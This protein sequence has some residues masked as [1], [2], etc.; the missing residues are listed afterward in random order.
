[1]FILHLYRIPFDTKNLVGYLI[2]VTIQFIQTTTNC[3]NN[4][5]LLS[6]GTGAF[7]LLV[8]ATEYIKYDLSEFNKYNRNIK[9]KGKLNQLKMFCESVQLYSNIKKLII[10]FIYTLR[11]LFCYF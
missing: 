6:L 2:A 11:N 1:M 5:N 10:N 9:G 7:W 4:A 8:T 3:F